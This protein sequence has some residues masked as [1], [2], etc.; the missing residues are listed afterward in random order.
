MAITA[1]DDTVEISNAI[2]SGGA[3]AKGTVSSTE[4]RDSQAR[5]GT[6]ASSSDSEGE[7]GQN[8]A[9]PKTLR[10]RP[11]KSGRVKKASHAKH[12]TKGDDEDTKKEKDLDEID[13]RVLKSSKKY[14]RGLK[15]GK[16]KEA[17]VA[18]VRSKKEQSKVAHDRRRREEAVIDA[19]RNEM[20][21]AESA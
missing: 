14:Q 15:M 13:K 7:D 17:A 2:G 5:G 12:N 10:D 4:A 18:D 21:L 19:A 11:A 20:L 3:F 16:G 6:H 1:G 8:E 9:P